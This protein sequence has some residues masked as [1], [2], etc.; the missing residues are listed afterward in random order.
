MRQAKRWVV[1]P[2]I[3]PDIE[4]R[5]SQAGYPTLIAQV[6]FNR[7]MIE[8]E[9]AQRF[10]DGELQ[11][12]DAPAGLLGMEAALDRIK[13]AMLRGERIVV[14]G[15]YD[16]DGVTATA[17]TVQVL[18]ALGAEVERYIPDREE[19]GYGLNA[20][21]LRKIKGEHGGRVVI[22]VDCGVRAHAEAEV[23]RELG[24]DLIVTDHHEPAPELPEAFAIINPKQPG[25]TYPEKDLAGVGLAYK[26]AQ[27]LV[28]PLGLDTPIKASDV[29]DL[30]ALGTVADMAPLTGENRRLVRLGLGVLNRGKREGVKALLQVARV[31]P[32]QV[33]A[34]TIGF[35]LG[36]RLNAAGRLESAMAAYDLLSTRDGVEALELAWKLE[37]QNRERQDLTR[38]AHARA[39]DLALA[40]G[41]HGA[42]LFAAHA[43][44]REGVVGL[45]A[46]RLMEEFYRPAVVVHCGPDTS[47]GSARSIP[48]FDITHA[49]DQVRPLLEKHGG[50][51]AAAG[52]TVRNDNLEALQRELEAIAEGTLGDKEL[53]PTQRIDA[54]QVPL[55]ALTPE[56]FQW[57]R[58][59][60]PCGFKNPTPV[61]ASRRLKVVNH[62][63]VG[64]DGKHLKLTVTD[65]HGLYDAI[66]FGQTP[67][68]G[69]VPP[70]V[71]LAYC[72]EMNEWQ[73]NLRLQL[74][75]KS[76]QAA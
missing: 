32:G 28:R 71:D 19:E 5:L 69:V 70:F 56:L 73:G 39:R 58:K 10:L 3:P 55:A 14:Y 33:D 4:S 72:L 15:D 21:A 27:G 20:D 1:E 60:E 68:D 64:G 7:G 66:A 31:R 35:A 44:F 23:A 2:P 9:A 59:F 37:A 17:L 47:K 76:L 41:T 54:D 12:P 74:N 48:E 62:R 11:A 43:D 40:R 16:S 18:R 75:V 50:H 63:L 8:P 22:T 26:L 53:R 36:P 6:L 25:D 24:L 29:L 65:G 46:A 30:V 49:L 42:L 51:K 45:A 34:S 67:A 13:H 52:F 61:L 57:L 38:Q